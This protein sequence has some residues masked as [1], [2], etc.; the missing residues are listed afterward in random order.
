MKKPAFAICVCA[1]LGACTLGPN[2][3]PPP[4]PQATAFNYSAPGTTEQTDP[5]PD[6]WKGFNDPELVW[7][8]RIV[9][10]GNP[11]LQ[12]SL[13]R[14]E[15]AHQATAAQL[16]QGLPD[17]SASGS[18]TREEE[19]LKGLAESDGA[20][21]QL[22]TLAADANAVAPGTGG[23]VYNAANGVVDRLGQPINLFQYELRSSW[24]LDLFGRV[25]RSVEAARAGEA[26]AK[27]AARDSLVM[28]EAQA[29]QS[30]F[31]LREAQAELARQRR[32][33]QD[34]KL[35]LQLTISQANTGLA[36][37]VDVDQARTEYLSARAQLPNFEK[38]ISE[39]LNQIDILAGQPPGTLDSRLS[40][41]T[42]LPAP[43]AVIGAGVPSN[44]A[45]R[46][47]DI[48][49]AED[50]LHQE[51]AQIGVAVASFYPDI[52]LTGSLGYRSLD[53]SYLTHWA[54]LFYGVGPSISLPI[55]QGGALIANLR[56][57]RIAQANAALQYRATVLNALAEVEN[58]LVA[59]RSDQQ[60]NEDAQATVQSALDNSNLAESRYASGLDSFLPTL[61]AERTLFADQQQAIETQAQLDQDVATLYTALGGGW[62]ETEQAPVAPTVDNTPPIAPAAI[63]AL[64]P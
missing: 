41:V 21:N 18:F 24:E 37:Q 9:I 36:P 33:V 56:T 55:F 58:A 28:L 57:A 12:E 35:T 10:A 7:L 42:A 34:A 5:A 47:P 62:Q 26:Q 49:A 8:M 38:Q 54:N 63:D 1:A 19:G 31:Q 17:L 3:Q 23:T 13:L 59:Y 25:R 11:S 61:D 15:Q 45:R 64:T 50:S 29:A 60:E 22:D 20:Y 32:N 2:F 48:R 46:R 51:T 16:A 27:D 14:V 4:P 6:W 43:P 52:S 40:I 30:Y 44:L 53:A 39:T